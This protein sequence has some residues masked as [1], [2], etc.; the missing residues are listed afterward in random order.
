MKT[1][2]NGTINEIIK[3]LDTET[4]HKLREIINGTS[5]SSIVTTNVIYPELKDRSDSIFCFLLMTG[6]LKSIKTSYTAR[7]NI[8]CQLCI[9]NKEIENVYYNEILAQRS[10]SVSVNTARLGKKYLFVASV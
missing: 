8:L 1:S 7:G 5:V 10:E 3:S 9:P 4:Y 2:S 6:Y